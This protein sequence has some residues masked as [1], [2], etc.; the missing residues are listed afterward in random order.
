MGT[1]HIETESAFGSPDSSLSE[2]KVRYLTETDGTTNLL[3]LLKEMIQ[4]GASDLH[5]TVGSPPQFR[6]DGHL[7]KSNHKVMDKN[8]TRRLCY[9]I[10]DAKQIEKFE[11]EKELDF[12]FGVQ[13]LSRFRGNI[14]LQRGAVAGV[15]RTIPYEVP[16][17]EALGLP[18]ILNELAGKPRGLI[19]VSG[20]NGSG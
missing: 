12:S 1:Q 19:L 4:L 10:L 13:G 2:S 17:F 18:E 16:G 11:R 3:D 20:R 5:I 9:S 7:Q 14:Y 8:E 15:F 6:I